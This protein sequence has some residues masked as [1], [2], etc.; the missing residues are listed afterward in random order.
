MNRIDRALRIA[1]GA[2]LL[3]AAI[4]VILSFPGLVSD[5]DST[6]PNPRHALENIS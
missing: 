3:A 6:V 2:V 1:A 5:R 4:T